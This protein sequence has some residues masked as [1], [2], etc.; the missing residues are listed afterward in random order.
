MVVERVV[1]NIDVAPTILEAAGIAAPPHFDGRS[2][3]PLAQGK[4]VPWRDYFLYVYY[5]E[6]NFPQSPTVFSLRG[7]RYK[8]ITYYGLWDA[9]ELYDLQTDPDE[10]KNLLYDPK[11]KPIATSMEKRLYDM[12]AELGGMEIPL[13]APLG[14]SSNKRLRSR[15]GDRASDFPA[16]LV[17]EKPIN[18][19]AN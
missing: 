10:A 14:A 6:K 11:F 17:V 1:A 18:T 12:M 7:E 16:A 9:D 15:D 4:T 8:Y 2:F 3:V 13:N 19:N 5:W